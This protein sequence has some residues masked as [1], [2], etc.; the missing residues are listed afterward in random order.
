MWAFYFKGIALVGL[1]E[2]ISNWFPLVLMALLAFILYA[3]GINGAMYYDDIRPLSGLSNVIDMSS[4]L[5]YV[6]TEISGPLGR[7]VSMLSFLPHQNDRLLNTQN[8]F[9]INIFI[10][11]LN[12]LLVALIVKRVS[13]VRGEGNKKSRYFALGVASLWVILPLHASSSLIAIQRMTT[14]SALFV[15]M[16]ILIYVNSVGVEKSD[17]ERGGGLRY[18][19]LIICMGLAVLSK[20]NGILLPVFILVIDTI[21]LR[22]FCPES[23]FRSSMRLFGL[24]ALF[25]LLFYVLYSFINSL[26]GWGGRDFNVLERV[27]TQPFVLTSYLLNGF[28]PR[29][30]ELHP[31]HDGYPKVDLVS[32]GYV[33]F[34]GLFLLLLFVVILILIKK[35]HPIFAFSFLWFFSAHLLESTTLNLELYFEHR[36][37]LALIGPCFGIVWAVKSAPGRLSFFVRSGFIV[38]LITVSVILYHVTTLWG[39]KL[40]AAE[41]WFVHS[42]KSQRAAEH[43]ALL[44][45]ENNNFTAAYETMKAQVEDCP[46]CLASVLQATLLACVALDQELVEKY[47]KKAEI[48]SESVRKVG[49]AATT[50]S[51]IH[52][53]INAGKCKLIDYDRIV[54]MNHALLKLQTNGLGALNRKILH[55]NLQ[56]LARDRNNNELAIAHLFQAWNADNDLQLGVVIVDLLTK[57][58]LKQDARKFIENDLCA[59]HPLHPYRSYLLNSRCRELRAAIAG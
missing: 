36:N 32:S 11:S 25:S 48:L 18:Y 21:L 58:N 56:R 6:F 14:M 20:E 51:A 39:N 44:Q 19:G 46:E 57:N 9:I 38:Y 30:Y 28:F 55:I 41:T 34:F 17:K 54:G 12:F 50:L 22:D 42:Y 47:L 7:P 1:R 49:G 37:Y 2:R 29:P 23:R 27:A 5:N 24:L 59:R 26:D 53:A 45:L 33:A 31:F 8:I 16:G 4:A 35:R 52:D 13:D 40:D 10:H 3:P 15:L 43:L